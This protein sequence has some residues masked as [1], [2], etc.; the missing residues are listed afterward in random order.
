MA[1]QTDTTEALLT[2][3]RAI[4]H[5]FAGT[6]ER[7]SHGAPWFHV[8]GKG[9]LTFANDHHGDGRVA[10]WCL[11]LIHISEPTRPY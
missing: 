6:E 4:C 3:V 5:D 1:D 8:R 10:V 11:S 7:L 2:R 9:M